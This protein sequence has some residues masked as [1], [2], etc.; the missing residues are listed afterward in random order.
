MNV[1]DILV[2]RA[3]TT[4][5]ACVGRILATYGRATPAD[6]VAG[7]AWYGDASDVVTAVATAGGFSREC[8]AAVIAHLSPRTTWQRNIAGAKAF[9]AGFKGPGVM[10]ANY[11]RAWKAY[12]EYLAGRDPLDTVKGPK[13]SAFALNLLGEQYAVTV[14]V[15][16][17]RVALCDDY[18]RGEL[19]AYDWIALT[20][21]RKGVYGAVEFAYQRA[22]DMR[23][24]TPQAMQAITW[25]VQRN[26]RA[27]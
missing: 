13:T 20:L 18:A 3:D 10:Q 8:A 7:A 26:G 25:I 12:V 17:A 27:G 23:G 2:K 24:V 14:D 11:D 21:N 6:L 19:G 1:N 5:D 16:A 9:A 22:A 4:L 15:H